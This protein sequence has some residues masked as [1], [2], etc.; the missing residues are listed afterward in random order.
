M[1]RFDTTQSQAIP[2]NSKKKSAPKVRL[3]AITF[4]SFLAV[5]CATTKSSLSDIS[6]EEAAANQQGCTPVKYQRDFMA[7]Q[8]M[9]QGSGRQCLV[10]DLVLRHV[11]SIPEG[12]REM[13]RSEKVVTLF[14]TDHLDLDL[15]G[16]LISGGPFDNVTGITLGGFAFEA[17]SSQRKYFPEHLSVRNGIIKTPGPSGVGV[18]LGFGKSFELSTRLDD[19]SREPV[20]EDEPPMA[21][22][23]PYE[24]GKNIA[25][26]TP[27]NY[28]PATYF[29]LDNLKISSGGRGV[30]MVGA[31]NTLRNSTVEVDGDTA[32]YL[33]GPNALVEGNTFIIH[34]KPG[35][36][37]QIPSVLKL[38]DADGAIIRNNKF[39]VKGR[40]DRQEVAAINL[41]ASSNV[42]IEN[43]VTS[44]IR[45]LVRKDDE[46]ALAEGSGNR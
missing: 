12:F 15:Q 7:L 5:A 31:N 41:L 28:Q 3:I 39:I 24:K 20:P 33:Y 45:Q 21:E 30:I 44:D 16:H 19:S 36:T 1:Q 35:S 9:A 25:Y 8:V 32:V 38:R 4:A 14:R 13:G 27:W 34:M 22:M 10:Q 29:S 43:N 37:S 46:S 23:R 17:S 42:R 40:A 26:A 11:R 6:R 2:G 18:Y